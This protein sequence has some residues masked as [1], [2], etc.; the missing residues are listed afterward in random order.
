MQGLFSKIFAG[1]SC[2]CQAREHLLCQ[3]CKH[4]LCQSFVS[5]KNIFSRFHCAWHAP[6]YHHDACPLA[7]ITP[8]GHLSY[9]PPRWSSYLPTLCA[10]APNLTTCANPVTPV[11]PRM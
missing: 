10:R 9:H 5:A 6:C 8:S 4:L 11:P 7:P 2:A 3:S 1:T